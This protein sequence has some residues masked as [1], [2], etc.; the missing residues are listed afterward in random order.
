MNLD[1]LNI[2]EFLEHSWVRKAHG[3]GIIATLALPWAIVEDHSD[4]LSAFLLLYP[5][6]AE[7]QHQAVDTVI[8]LLLIGVIVSASAVHLYVKMG[9]RRGLW[10]AW[11]ITIALLLLPL[12]ASE[13]VVIWWGWAATLLLIVPHPTV[14]CVNEMRNLP[15]AAWASLKDALRR[16]R[17]RKVR[18]Q[19]P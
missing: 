7:L 14:W 10:T 6:F 4:A 9:N 18:H 17:S 13:A 15:G 2:N 11:M 19:Q 3:V 8:A 5:V 16:G 12:L 1:T